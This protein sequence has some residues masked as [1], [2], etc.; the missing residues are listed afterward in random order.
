MTL[1]T[2]N[3]KLRVHFK[4]VVQRQENKSALFLSLSLNAIDEE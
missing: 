1:E 3:A 4:A 2:V